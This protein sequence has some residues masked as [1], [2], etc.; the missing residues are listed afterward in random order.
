MQKTT[1]RE[2]GEDMR[3]YRPEHDSPAHI[4]RMSE[5]GD[6]ERIDNGLYFSYAKDG[7]FKAYG[8]GVEYDLETVIWVDYGVAD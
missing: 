3:E 8:H 6:M 1:L 2:Y 7:S 4:W 5:S